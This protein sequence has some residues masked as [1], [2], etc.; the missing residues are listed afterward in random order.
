[1]YPYSN[2]SFWLLMTRA[3]YFIST[4]FNMLLFLLRQFCYILC[5]IRLAIRVNVNVNVNVDV[6][7]DVDVKRELNEISVMLVGASR[8]TRKEGRKGGTNA[9][10]MG[11]TL[12]SV[13][14]FSFDAKLVTLT[15]RNPVL[16][17]VVLCRVA[18]CC[19]LSCLLNPIPYSTPHTCAEESE[20]K[21]KKELILID[22]C[23][24]VI[25]LSMRLAC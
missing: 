14:E 25:R 21:K 20:K 10:V 19:V 2:D 6:D 23:Q 16:G 11:M 12:A 1:M 17:C 9:K 3:E 22:S 15:L 13:P 24:S 18:L 5:T 4:V 8:R 7:V